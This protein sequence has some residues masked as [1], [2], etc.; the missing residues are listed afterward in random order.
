MTQ[1][2]AGG[3]GV[4]RRYVELLPGSVGMALT[5]G[6][7]A[8]WEAA[9]AQQRELEAAGAPFGH[10]KEE[11]WDADLDKPVG[12]ARPACGAVLLPTT[13][14]KSAYCPACLWRDVREYGSDG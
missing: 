6:E 1:R 2:R 12:A 13:D 5:E 4:A 10:C 9:F 7:R 11:N 8:E 14:G 3:A